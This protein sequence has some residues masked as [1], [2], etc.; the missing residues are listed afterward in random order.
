MIASHTTWLRFSGLLKSICGMFEPASAVPGR[1]RDPSVTPQQS[2]A[3]ARRRR[4]IGFVVR[5]IR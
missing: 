4:M 3:V 2:E 1:A 5:L